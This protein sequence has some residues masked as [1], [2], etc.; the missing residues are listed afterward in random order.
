MTVNNSKYYF[1]YLN[2]LVDRYNNTY[3]SSIDKKP[4][5]VAYSALTE[6]TEP[7]HKAPKFKVGDSV[8]IIKQKNIFSKGC[9]ENWS[10]EIILLI[11]C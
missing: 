5:D 1:G 2:K 9:N 10:R 8:R 3:N 11:L 7:S 4:V 6:E